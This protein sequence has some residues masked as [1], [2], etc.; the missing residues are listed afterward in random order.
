[1]RLQS[2]LLIAVIPVIVVSMLSLGSIAYSQFSRTSERELLMQMRQVLSQVE[3]SGHA[4]L[5]TAQA[6]AKL[7]AGSSLIKRY[8]LVDDEAER[9]DLMQ[10][11]LLRLFASYRQAF[12]IYQ[13]IRLV[14]PDGF[15]DTRLASAGMSNVSEEEADSAWFLQAQANAVEPLT[16]GFLDHPD[17]LDNALI[18]TRPIRLV[19]SNR[20][21]DWSVPKLRGYLSVTVSTDAL[22]EMVGSAVIGDSGQLMLV[23]RSG[24]L[25]TPPRQRVSD[26]EIRSTLAHFSSPDLVATDARLVIHDK[27]S[28]VQGVWLHPD[29]LL[30]AV[31]PEAEFTRA[32]NELAAVVV[33]VTAIAIVAATLVLF[34]LLRSVVIRPVL[35]LGS[36]AVAL[37]EGKDFPVPVVKRSD[38]LGDLALAFRDMKSALHESMQELQSSHARIEQL[39]YRDTLTQLPNRRLFQ[40][41]LESAI[42]RARATETSLAVLFLDLDEFKKVNDSQGHESGDRLLQ[43]VAVRLQSCVRDTGPG[44]AGKQVEPDERNPVARIG[45]DEFILL[46]DDLHSMDEASRVAQRIVG[47]IAQPVRVGDQDFVVG[48]SIGIAHWPQQASDV[49]G[50]IKCA[51]MAMYEAKRSGKNTY[52]HYGSA[53]QES[54]TE[55]LSMEADLRIALADGQMFLE[56]QPQFTTMDQRIIGVEALLRWRHPTQGSISPDVFVPVAEEIGLISDIGQWVLDEACRQWASWR[57]AGLPPVRLAVNVSQRQFLAGDLC[58]RVECAIRQHGMQAACL[59]IEL[60]ESCIME[61]PADVVR[62]L[63]RIRRLGVRVAM[64]DFG[65]GYSSL[66]ALTSLPID[67][68]KIDRSFIRGIAPETQG[69]KVVSAIITLASSLDLE[70]V[71]EGVETVAELRLL[72]ERHCDV[73]QGYLLSRPLAASTMS[74]LLGELSRRGEHDE[75]RRAG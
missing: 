9:F 36:A 50:L 43:E 52:R 51:D 39:A 44:A 8:V 35:A 46:L 20:L 12:P 63:I 49:D 2:K 45:G 14:L 67:T 62:T 42:A 13:E 24:R 72:E 75:T 70:T 60:T 55:R 48:T 61:A 56:Y 22:L 32:S 27:P 21:A 65:T 10:P 71:A 26:R 30:A 1:M 68:L 59:E 25:M 11:A 15:E 57:R 3:Q 16:V 34:L 40:Q 7:F 58:E 6:N 37:G 69:E 23:H 73:V 53:M 17:G 4:L 38:E 47:A 5:E 28:L 31:V 74:A 54:L 41:M 18:V 29:V 19:D 33:A 66:A 64:D